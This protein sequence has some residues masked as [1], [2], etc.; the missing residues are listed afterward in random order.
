MIRL[1]RVFV[2]ASTFA[3][4][5]FEI[6]VI[7]SAF[8]FSTYL[9]L[10][11]DPTDYLLNNL[12]MVS[13]AL[14]SFSVLAGLYLQD[15]YSQVRV[16][17][18]LL[19]AQQLLMV[20]GIAFLLQALISAVAP[21]LYLPFKVVC[22]GCFITIVAVFTGRLLFSIYVLPR[23]APERFLLMG[24]SPVLEDISTYLAERPQLGI[25]VAGHI[26]EPLRTDGLTEPAAVSLSNLE[27]LIR[28][29]RSNRVVVG[30]PRAQLAGDLL[31]LRFLGYS[32]QEAAATY[33][34]ISNREALRGLGP[35]RLLYSKE[36]EPSARDLFFQ[37]ISTTLV[38]GTCAIILSP[39]ML[40]IALLVRLCSHGRVLERQTRIG[41]RGVPFTLYRFRTNQSAAGATK[42]EVLIG[43][44]LSRTGLY[45]IPQFFNVLRGEM[46]IVG[47]RPH[48]SEFT[49]EV[50]RHIPF[51]PHR[52]KMRPGMTGLAQIE[53]RSLSGP[54]DCMVELEYDMYYLKYMSPMMDLF[55]IL[56]SVK[57]ILFWGGQ[58]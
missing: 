50:T 16:K 20:V 43:R 33:A 25:Q 31:E 7:V 1:F 46:S 17:S 38:A 10:D 8:T 29:C 27:E 37:T 2:P 41:K 13:V 36:F 12:G 23:V 47:P 19:L 45:A 53:M 57:N 26:R 34:K 28:H 11:L 58:P 39:L 49:R 30:T 3:L 9:L 21:D 55:I 42:G 32:I 40:L 54:P 44:F 5:V 24:D 52:L 15:L 51:Y 4:L 56:Q 48:R 18:R 6:V 14:V 22:L 35:A